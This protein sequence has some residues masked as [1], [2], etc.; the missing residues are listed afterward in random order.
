MGDLSACN[1][2]SSPAE[3]PI[4]M[5]MGNGN[6]DLSACNDVSLPAEYP[7]LMSMGTPSAGNS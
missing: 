6:G 1:D 2:V 4:L 7:I 3:H 5:S